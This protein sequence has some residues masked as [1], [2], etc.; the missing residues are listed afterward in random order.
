MLV[1]EYKA[2]AF[3]GFEKE[4][5]CFSVITLLSIQHCKFTHGLQSVW[6]II[7]EFDFSFFKCFG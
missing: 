5:F 6:M 2:T 7:T 1:A 4:W 3:E